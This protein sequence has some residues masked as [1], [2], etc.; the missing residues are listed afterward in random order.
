MVLET[1]EGDLGAELPGKLR[2]PPI[3]RHLTAEN[4]GDASHGA[5]AAEPEH[6]HTLV[7]IEGIA[8]LLEVVLQR[9]PHRD[10]A[11]DQMLVRLRCLAWATG[12]TCKRATPK[13]AI[14]GDICERETPSSLSETG[15]ARSDGRIQCQQT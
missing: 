11:L 6:Q 7:A 1:D 3:P 5:L 12:L 4:L 10:A 13:D 8:T 14:R 2:R 9:L 15:G